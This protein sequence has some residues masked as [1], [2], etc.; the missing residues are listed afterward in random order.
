[1]TA[2]T[3]GASTTLLDGAPQALVVD[4]FWD[5]GRVP[6]ET[7][8]F[9]CG[10]TGRVLSDEYF[11]FYNQE[12]SPGG[13]VIHRRY[14]TLLP[15]RAQFQIHVAALPQVAEQ[16]DVVLTA[17]EGDLEHVTDVRLVVWD[18]GTGDDLASYEAPAAGPARS[19]LLGQ[20]YRHQGTWKVRALGAHYDRDL[21]LVAQEHGVNV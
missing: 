6:C 8:M 1:M 19:S 7:V 10:A 9:V 14:P 4:V 3:T 12:R 16:L 17:Q 11:V 21:A 13:E 15:Q 2:L 5:S 20:L 18:P